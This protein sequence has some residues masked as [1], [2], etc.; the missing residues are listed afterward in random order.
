MSLIKG[1]LKNGN[2]C[3]F[4]YE[5]LKT[6]SNALYTKVYLADELSQDN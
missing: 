6:L 3:E 4:T 1:R 5:E 2:L